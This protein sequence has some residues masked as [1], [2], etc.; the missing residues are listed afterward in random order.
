MTGFFQYSWTFG[1]RS[2][3]VNGLLNKRFRIGKDGTRS[4]RHHARNATP[5]ERDH[6]N[7]MAQSFK[8]GDGF[9]LIGVARRKEQDINA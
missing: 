3:R 5:C 2:K 6:R 8:N 4:G 9:C 1:Q 7:T